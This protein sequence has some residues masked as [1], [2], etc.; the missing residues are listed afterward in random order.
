MKQI[1]NKE[2]EKYQ[3][4][5]TDK[6]H[7]RIILLFVNLTLQVMPDQEINYEESIHQSFLMKQ[8]IALWTQRSDRR[9]QDIIGVPMT[10]MQ[11][12]WV[13]VIMRALTIS[14]GIQRFVRKQ[15]DFELKATH[16]G[17]NLNIV[18]KND[19][20]IAST[21]DGTLGKACVYDADYSAIADGHVTIIRVDKQ[22][23][24]PY[25]LADYIR[26]GFGAIQVN[27]LYTGSTG[28]IELI[29]EQVDCLVIET[30]VFEEQ[31]RISGEIRAL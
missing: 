23:I 19:V 14:I 24:Y 28:L 27:L 22:K 12:W 1:S 15:K 5:Q 29:P 25:Y 10:S 7:G 8:H 21:R 18:K 30:P 13:T 16:S 4:Y 26:N 9:V 20:L 11:Q 6:L 2:Y 31:V 17:E 3:Q